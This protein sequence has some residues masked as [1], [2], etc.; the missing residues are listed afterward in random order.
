MRAGRNDGDDDGAV[1]AGVDGMATA[2]G[3]SGADG[4][5]QLNRLGDGSRA[6]GKFDDGGGGSGAVLGGRR[7]ERRRRRR[8]RS[9][10]RGGSRSRSSRLETPGDA[11]GGGARGEVH[12]VGAAP[13]LGLVVVGA[14]VPVVAGICGC[15][16]ASVGRVCHA[17]Y[18]PRACSSGIHIL[19]E[20]SRQQFC[21]APGL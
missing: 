13:G 2:G 11:K 6:G 4:G 21:L 3:G 9:R 14:V 1:V 10:R 20:P 15:W 12:G 7:R 8:S 5:G 18:P 19:P 16:S 17:R